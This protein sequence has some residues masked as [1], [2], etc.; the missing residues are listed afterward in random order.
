MVNPILAT[1]IKKAMTEGFNNQK[2]GGDTPNEERRPGVFL[3][4]ILVLIILLITGAELIVKNNTKEYDLGDNTGENNNI[5]MKEGFSES[6]QSTT[7]QS[8]TPSSKCKKDLND[9]KKVVYITYGSTILLNIIILFIVYYIFKSIFKSKENSENDLNSVKYLYMVSFMIMITCILTSY[10][11]KV[12]KS[13]RKLYFYNYIGIPG[14]GKKFDSKIDGHDFTAKEFTL[15][16][17]T[18]IIFGFIDNFGLFFGMDSLDEF[19]NFDKNTKN[20]KIFDK[21]ME[22][23]QNGGNI[24]DKK[25]RIEC[26]YDNP[27]DLS[28][29]KTAGWGNTFSDFL[30]AF[31]GNAVGDISLTLANVEK[32]P[33]IS[34]ILGIVIGCVIGIYIP[35]FLKKQWQGDNKECDYKYNDDGSV[36]V[37]P[38]EN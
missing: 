33:I 27:N 21:L 3:F 16:M 1:I 19:L 5:Q 4:T 17:I 6:P 25:K 22:P 8:T 35:A 9:Y 31:V 12:Y 29:L 30:G 11:V 38:P 13:K 18:N 32:T 26:L 23:N 14:F 24:T 20:K 34:E 37:K 7:S 2:G 28:V 36:Y 15:G 10:I